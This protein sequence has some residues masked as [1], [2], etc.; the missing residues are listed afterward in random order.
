MTKQIVFAIALLV[1][2][3]VFAY[4]VSRIVR[5]FMLTRKGFKVDKLGKRFWVTL[6]VAF[7]QTKIF[8]RPVI[9]LMHAL[10]FWGF[11]VILFGSIEMVID[12]LFGVEK[13]LSVLGAFYNFMMAAGDVF[14]LLVAISI[15]VFLFR[16]VFLHIKRF[17][18]IEMKKISHI[19]ANVALSIILVLML[20]LMGVNAAYLK[21]VELAGHEA[22]GVYL[23]SQYLTWLFNGMTVDAVFTH[24]QVYWWIHILLIF[25]FANLLPYSKHFHVFMS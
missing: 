2:L 24:Y 18:G 19:D 1:T 16:R 22:Q 23:V 4:T 10:V 14:A 3:G 8:R 5:F 20:S 7:G 12:G 17:E 9:G 11:C 21:W 13:S 15:V 6:K 25:L